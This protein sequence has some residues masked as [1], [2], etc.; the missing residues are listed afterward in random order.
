MTVST[1]T[2]PEL[3]V[4][5]HRLGFPSDIKTAS[6]VR[7]AARDG[8]LA[9]EGRRLEINGVQL[10]PLELGRSPSEPP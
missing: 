3:R 10:D 5:L 2:L 4:L 8:R 1:L 7:Q 6:R 9:W